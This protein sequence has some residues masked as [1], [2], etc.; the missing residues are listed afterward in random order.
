M[1]V[2]SYIVALGVLIEVNIVLVNERSIGY[3]KL[4]NGKLRVCDFS[5][6][7]LGTDHVYFRLVPYAPTHRGCSKL[8]ALPFSRGTGLFSIRAL[9]GQDS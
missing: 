2:K 1:F 9:M 5:G 8:K 6:G 4:F 3:F 7:Q